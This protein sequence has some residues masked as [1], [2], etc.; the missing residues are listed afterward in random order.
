LGEKYVPSTVTGEQGIYY[1]KENDNYFVA[2]SD[3]ITNNPTSVLYRK[4][5]YL[6]I[7]DPGT[8]K[9]TLITRQLNN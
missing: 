8:Y 3:Y 5:G 1:Y 6:K 7:S 2:N 4:A 9:A